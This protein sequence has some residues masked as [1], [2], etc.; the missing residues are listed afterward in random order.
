[1]V[2]I[3]DVFSVVSLIFAICI[4]AWATLLG[5]ALLFRQRTDLAQRAIENRPWR[6]FFGGLFVLLIVGTIAIGLISN[7]VPVIKL[8]GTILALGLL[9]IAAIGAGGLCQLIAGRMQ[10]LDPTLSPYRAIGRSAAI[11]V[12]AGLL[13]LV[14][15]WVFMPVVLAVSLGAGFSALMARSPGSS[16]VE[17]A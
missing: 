10:P 4:S 11:L 9:S 5:T 15:W 17:A 6:A 1:M 2:T 3:G 16:M 12:I 13:P 8:S 7:P 14:G